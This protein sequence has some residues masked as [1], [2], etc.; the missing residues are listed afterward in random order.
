MSTSLLYHALR[1]VGYRYFRTKYASGQLTF[2]IQHDDD[3][4]GH[5]QAS[6]RRRNGSLRR[7]VRL[8]K[9]DFK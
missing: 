9:N 4:P 2:H 7:K 5:S 1:A 8:L 6:E 3:N